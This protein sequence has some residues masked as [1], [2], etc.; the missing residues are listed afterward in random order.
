MAVEYRYHELKT[1]T[2]GRMTM[3]LPVL[4]Q[5]QPAEDGGWWC[6]DPGGEVNLYARMDHP[7]APEGASTAAARVAAFVD[8]IRAFLEPLEPAE[9]IAVEPLGGGALVRAVLTF[10]HRGRGFHD[11][12]WYA[13]TD[14]EPTVIFRFRLMFPSA[15]G[16]R[17]EMA[18]L[19]SLFDDQARRANVSRGDDHRRSRRVPGPPPPGTYLPQRETDVDGMVAFRIPE[20][21]RREYQN[22]GTWWF[23][24][25]DFLGSLLLHVSIRDIGGH[26]DGVDVP[27]FLEETVNERLRDYADTAA[28]SDMEV[29][30]VEDGVVARA[31]YDDPPE[32]AALDDDDAGPM[33]N[34]DWHLIGRCGD[35]FAFV[36]FRLLVPVS[37]AEAP[38]FRELAE[39]LEA[40]IHA[41]RLTAPPHPYPSSPTLAERKY[42]FNDLKA[43]LILDDHLCLCVPKR[44]L[45]QQA[46]SGSWGFF[47]EDEEDEETG[48]LWVD[49]SWQPFGTEATEELHRAMEDCVRDAVTRPPGPAERDVE[50][51]V[52][53]ETED[54]FRCW[55]TYEAKEDGE[56]LRFTRCDRL[57]RR[58]EGQLLLFFSFVLPAVMVDDPEMVELRDIVVREVNAAWVA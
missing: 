51:A 14:L 35:G 16:R 15:D 18:E 40:G 5:L 11:V 36:L 30:R 52:I 23:Y 27:A 28:Y 34:R 54:G 3:G 55:R 43:A 38:A 45:W 42:R 22:G 4:W 9:D 7:P 2:F 26:P 37:V 8:E 32:E 1:V 44:W 53:E 50:P 47:E 19:I 39:V 56:W 31:V 41:A 13:V 24:D 33:R 6:N 20:R 46:P 25:P 48:T 17:P 10:D 58:P 57:C 29:V 21:W 49:W 12:R